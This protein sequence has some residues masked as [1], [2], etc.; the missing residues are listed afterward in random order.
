[1]PKGASA[2]DAMVDPILHEI[3]GGD[4]P[5]VGGDSPDAGSP[6]GGAEL[7]WHQLDLA[8]SDL[9]EDANGEVVVFNDSNLRN[10]AL[11]TDASVIAEGRA[12][13]HVTAAGEDV[14]GF[15]F[16]TFDNGMTLY[17]ESYLEVTVRH[18]HN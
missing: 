13:S 1:M 10:L 6:G 17:F 12:S 15:K 16:V 14:S 5:D 3:R 11:T 18:E 9:I 7:T 8:L 2:R 4:G